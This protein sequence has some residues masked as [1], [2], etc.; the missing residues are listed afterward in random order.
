MDEGAGGDEEGEPLKPR[1]RG[2]P[3]GTRDELRASEAVGGKENNA[4]A[5][6]PVAAGVDIDASI[7]VEKAQKKKRGR[8]ST[9]D[10]VQDIPIVERNLQKKRGR[11]AILRTEQLSG[12]ED[13]ATVRQTSNANLE[14]ATDSTK[15]RRRGRPSNTQDEL[16]AATAP[17]ASIHTMGKKPDARRLAKENTGAKSERRGRSSNTEAEVQA[18]FEEATRVCIVRALYDGYPRIIFI[19]H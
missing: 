11:P 4:P 18:V 15:P 16:E 6:R 1:R 13:A 19:V 12:I 14:V 17:P 7:D 10:P 3:S 8:P 5:D 2:R 9:G